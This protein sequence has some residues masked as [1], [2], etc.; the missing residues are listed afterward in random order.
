MA[1]EISEGGGAM[2]VIALAGRN[3]G[4]AEALAENLEAS[5]GRVGG[6]GAQDSQVPLNQR[7]GIS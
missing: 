1:S 2:K 6:H 3:V 7:T 4:T 5:I